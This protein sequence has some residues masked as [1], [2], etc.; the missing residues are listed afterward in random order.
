LR[1]LGRVEWP[2]S[3]LRLD[4]GLSAG[5]SITAEGACIWSDAGVLEAALL[6]LA[7][8]VGSRLRVGG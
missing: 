6:S 8:E 7:V 1:V 5:R 4:L 3:E 2:S